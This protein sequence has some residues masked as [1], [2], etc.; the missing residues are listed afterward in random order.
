[1]TIERSNELLLEGPFY[2]TQR[3]AEALKHV[4]AR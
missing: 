2:G 4:V 3:L 1:M